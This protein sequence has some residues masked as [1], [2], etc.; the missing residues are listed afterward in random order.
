[1][2]GIKVQPM[3]AS[4]EWSMYWP[5]PVPS[6]KTCNTVATVA[7]MCLRFAALIF[8]AQA[9][10]HGEM[11]GF[12][13]ALRGALPSI[14]S[15]YGE[16]REDP[17]D[18]IEFENQGARRPQRLE[19]S[20]W[21][22]DISPATIGAGFF[23]DAQGAFVTAAH[24]VA[25]SHRVLVK[26]ADLQVAVAEIVGTDEDTDIAVLR[27]RGLVSAVP[28]F[29]RP[30]ASRP[31]D[32]VLAVGEP[33]GLQ[34]SVVA[35]IVSGRTRHLAEDAEGFFIQS[36]IAM[37]PGNSGGPLLNA[38]GAIIGM[39]LRT[40]VGPYGTAGVSLS[41]P[42]DIVLQIAEEIRQG[43]TRRPRLGATFEDVSPSAA[44]AAGR[45]YASGAFVTGLRDAGLGRA[46]GLRL[47]DIVIG[48]N[49]QPI[50]DSAD[51]ARWLLAW[52]EARGTRLVVWRE[53]AYLALRLP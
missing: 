5:S 48:M 25:G 23:L 1:M 29:G 44:L 45:R 47:G 22:A 41:I 28:A 43:G 35:G 36:D 49:G 10:A 27:V 53:G 42:I 18:V 14:V 40:V 34:R 20:P 39:N 50:E 24:V 46:M 21:R 3:G 38:S 4:I 51:L 13:S 19:R 26:T 8:P 15:V 7:A 52:R 9:A 6:L 16:G 12:S 31:G 11:P 32:W 2:T 33:F 37:N 17:H 30:A